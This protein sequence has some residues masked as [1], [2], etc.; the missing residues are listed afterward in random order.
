MSEPEKFTNF[1]DM[2]VESVREYCL[3]LPLV[4]EDTAFGDD[5]ILFRV[6]DK[7]FACLSIDGDDY[8]AVKC[9][10]VY[11]EELRERYDDIEPAWHWNKKFWNQL[12]ITSGSLSDTMIVSLIR[13]SYSE[14][15]KKLP[16][17]VRTEHPEVASVHG[18]IDMTED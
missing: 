14:V 12:H 7:I 10:P 9:D 16:R 3:S 1:A 8:L 17:R 11:A 5:N 6:F 4:T 18:D 2:N 13:H 15:V